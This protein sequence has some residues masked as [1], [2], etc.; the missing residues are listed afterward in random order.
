MIDKEVLK[1]WLEARINKLKKDYDELPS[2]SGTKTSKG[3]KLKGLKECL[4]YI[5]SH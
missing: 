3:G 4:D 2:G 5:N 1:N